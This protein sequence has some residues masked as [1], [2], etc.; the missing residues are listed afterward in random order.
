MSETPVPYEVRGWSHRD[1]EVI[2]ENTADDAIHAL[3]DGMYPDKLEDIGDVTVVEWK[4]R[5]IDP[6]DFGTP[7]MDVIERLHE[8]YGNPD[9]C[10]P[11]ESITQAMKDAEQAFLEV[12][13][14]E[15]RVWMCEPTGNRVT[16]NALEWA[17]EHEP[18]WLLEG[19]DAWKRRQGGPAVSKRQLYRGQP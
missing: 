12:V 8:D 5:K 18:E 2:V 1:A 7:L 4:A 9:D 11:E 3:L 16:V 19:A 13:M 15:Y 10:Y 14:R 17:R 6:Q